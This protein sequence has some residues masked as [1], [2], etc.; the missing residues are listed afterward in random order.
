MR[1]GKGRRGADPGPRD[2][3]RPERGGRGVDPGPR[4]PGTQPGQ[5]RGGRGLDPPLAPK[6]QMRK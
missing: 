2:P 1:G 6:A 4:D 5:E 3:A